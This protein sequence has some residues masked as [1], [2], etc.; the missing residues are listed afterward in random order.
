MRQA[1]SIPIK[2]ISGIALA[3]CVAGCVTDQELARIDDGKY[4][5]HYASQETK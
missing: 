2:P 1:S 4:G 5:R 3:A